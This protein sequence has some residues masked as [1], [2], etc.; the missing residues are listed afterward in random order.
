MTRALRLAARGLETTTP[1]PRVGCVLVRDGEIVGEG[2]HVRAGEPHAEVH[3][4]QAA[5]ARANGA[6]AYVTLEPCSHH[7]RTPPCADALVAAGVARVVAAMEDPNPVVSGRGLERLRAHG[8]VVD[9]GLLEAR[10]RELNPGFISRFVRHRPW[11]RVKIAASV[12]GRTALANGISQWIT[13][14]AARRDGHRWR[15]RSCVVMTGIG[16]LRDDDPRLTVRDVP[17]RRQPLRLVVDS[18]LQMRADARILEGGGVIVATA[19]GDAGHR[20]EL[21]AR[22]AEIWDLP[23]GTGKVDLAALM[24][25]LAERGH[26]EVLVEAGIN[27]HSALM[28]AGVVDE[29]ILY[30]APS[31]LGDTARGMLRLPPMETLDGR[32]D[33]EFHDVRRFGPD[34]RLLARFATP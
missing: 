8:I 6:T 24:A 26:N 29:L 19:N 12:D 7:G 23:D 10:A 11:V 4:L 30:L 3:A 25:R 14:P 9:G 34:L 16:T 32:L 17:C 27:L 33:F 31:M 28:A 2:F 13:G 20:A 1:N 21:E 18:R 5:G 15:A 22:G